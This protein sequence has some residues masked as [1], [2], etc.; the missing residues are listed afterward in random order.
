MMYLTDRGQRG[1]IRLHR[2]LASTEVETDMQYQSQRQAGR[3][4]HTHNISSSSASHA[5]DHGDE[6]K[7][8]YQQS[9][10]Q[11]AKKP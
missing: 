9:C 8:C 10:G 6:K 4:C 2:Q 5:I 1:V 7:V 11:M 3:S